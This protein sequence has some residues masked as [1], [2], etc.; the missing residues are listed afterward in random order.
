M[1][2]RF[3]RFAP[4]VRG[5]CLLV[6]AVQ[7]AAAAEIVVICP[8]AFRSAL[9]PWVQHR[10]AQGHS[11]AIYANSGTSEELRQHIRDQAAL[12]QDP[13]RFV[14]LVGDAEPAAATSP[15]LR[16]RSVPTHLTEAKVNIR[17]GSE[18]HIATDNWYADVDG[19]Q[20]PDLAIGRLTADTP[21]ELA[22]IVKKIVDYERQA[23]FG[24]WRGRINFVA[25]LGGFGALADAA[26]E[27][28][29]KKF[30]TE[31][32]PPAYETTMAY[33]SWR[34]PYCPDPREFHEVTLQ[35]LNEGSLFWVYIG[36]GHPHG[37]DQM[38]LAGQRYRI[39]EL[40]D[41]A[42]LRCQQGQPIALFLACYT[43]A[44]DATRDC[45]AEEMLRAPGGPVAILSGSRVTMPYAMS[46]LGSE[47][48]KECFQN[49]AATVGEVLLAAKRNSIL[50]PRTDDESKS[51]DLVAATLNT[52]SDL[53]EERREHLHLFNLIGDPTLR[54]PHGGRL[55]LEAPASAAPGETIEVTGEC[56][57]D[58]TCTIELVVRRDRLTFRP[59]ARR[60]PT[61]GR[62]ALDGYRDVFE[63]ANNPR[64]AATQVDAKQGRFRA[65]L[66]VP[67]SATGEC[68]IR[69]YVQGTTAAALGA[70]NLTIEQV[71]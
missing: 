26:L 41:V 3:G 34:S 47:M 19:D 50:R 36:H 45:L 64:L 57:I 8:G 9:E 43:G 69:A 17:W 23:D 21:N 11:I 18:P 46:V 33:A 71:R 55:R 6:L 66:A 14:V 53:L 52:G 28:V 62:D 70:A 1:N 2:Y 67:A 7:P 16:A 12:P 40:P 51:L 20:L 15:A 65:Q 32:V 49:H 31:G 38:Q 58:G 54:L 37:L 48:L 24:R 63:R 61:S 13:A 29:A 10:S 59:P 22:A 4:F 68:H 39:F 56:E 30:I 60:E 25:G 27:A 5:I 35:R 44:F 42:K